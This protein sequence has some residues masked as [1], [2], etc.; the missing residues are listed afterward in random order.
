LSDEIRATHQN[1][2]DGTAE[3]SQR[4]TKEFGFHFELFLQKETRRW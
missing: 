3:H 4:P 2:T 1:Q